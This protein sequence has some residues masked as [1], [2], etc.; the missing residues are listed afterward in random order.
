MSRSVAALALLALLSVAS[1]ERSLL[2]H[3]PNG[4]SSLHAVAFGS[5]NSSISSQTV[6]VYLS[7][8]GNATWTYTEGTTSTRSLM[9]PALYKAQNF[10]GSSIGLASGSYSSVQTVSSVISAG[11]NSLTFPSLKLGIAVGSAQGNGTTAAPVWPTVLTTQDLGLTWQFVTGFTGTPAGFSLTASTTYPDLTSVFCSTRT[12]C[13]AVGGYL[14]AEA[15]WTASPGFYDQNGPSYASNANNLAG[16]GGYPAGGSVINY[17]TNISFPWALGTAC[18][19]T[20]ANPGCGSF[21]ATAGQI[22]TFGAV[23]VST[24]GAT[25]WSFMPTGTISGLYAVGADSSGKHVYAVGATAG[26]VNASA[27]ASLAQPFYSSAPTII[28]SGNYGMSWVNQSAPVIPSCA[29]QLLSVFVLRGTMAYA[30]GGNLY[31]QNGIGAPAVYGFGTIVA[32]FNG[33]FTWS[34]QPIATFSNS[35]SVAGSTTNTAFGNGAGIPVINSISFITP[36]SGTSVGKYIGWAVG[37]NGLII[38]TT[39]GIPIKTLSNPYPTIPVN[40]QFTWS[41][42]GASYPAALV[43]PA[44]NALTAFPSAFSLYEI[45]WDNNAVGYIFGE[46]IILSTHT[47]GV[48][49]FV[50]TPSQVT[51]N[52]VTLTVAANV[53]TTY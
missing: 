50:E 9:N 46:G 8:N 42:L 36:T 41:A 48:T 18:A 29:Y 6:Q 45:V 15:A 53:P 26:V 11:I 52:S 24:N 21:T 28:Y 32:T 51:G 49:W 43:Y 33:G 14:P 23:L 16:T 27:L 44:G 2:A 12:L 19:S 22:S 37:E 5:Y 25:Q 40:V 31:S 17:Y 1:A 39:S 7:T 3:K 30:A 20:T 34:Q 38:K 13:F 10:Q 4:G 35:A 47:I